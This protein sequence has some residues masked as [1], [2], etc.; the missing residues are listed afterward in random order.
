MTDQHIEQLADDIA[1][2]I[3]ETFQG[4]S[5]I[6]AHRIAA[7]AVIRYRWRNPPQVDKD[8]TITVLIWE[9]DTDESVKTK[10]RRQI[11]EAI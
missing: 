6:S 10:I 5:L 7:S 9:S 3:S 8:Y 4:F 1:G 11:T 2:E